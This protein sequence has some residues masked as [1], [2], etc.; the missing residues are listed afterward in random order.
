VKCGPNIQE[1]QQKWAKKQVVIFLEYNFNLLLA[2]FKE[3]LHMIQDVVFPSW[4]GHFIPWKFPKV[5]HTVGL[6]NIETD[7]SQVAR[8]LLDNIPNVQMLARSRTLQRFTWAVSGN[9]WVHRDFNHHKAEFN[10]TGYLIN[11]LVF[12]AN[13]SVVSTLPLLKWDSEWIHSLSLNSMSSRWEA[14]Q[15]PCEMYH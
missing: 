9:N 2:A 3:R 7:W 10:W 13:R 12:I 14:W 11:P 6:L 4:L 5:G 15:L 8:F 1:N